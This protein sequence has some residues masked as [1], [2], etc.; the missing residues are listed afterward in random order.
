MPVA[1]RGVAIL[2]V[3][4][5]DL[6]FRRVPAGTVLHIRVAT[7]PQVAVTASTDGS[8]YTVGHNSIVVDADVPGTSYDIDLPSP[9][10]LPQ[11]SVRTGIRAVFLRQGAAVET[12][13]AQETDGSYT[14]VLGGG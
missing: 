5:V 8:T 11:V 14:I 13:G 12:P 4:H 6:L 1:P 3:G 7:G 2:A 9:T 10:S